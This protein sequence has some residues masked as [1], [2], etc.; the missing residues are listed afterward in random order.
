MEPTWPIKHT[1]SDPGHEYEFSLKVIQAQS[2]QQK[3]F[4]T[5]KKKNVSRLLER[6]LPQSWDG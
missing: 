6:I 1:Y 3:K 2:E 5:K 4:Q